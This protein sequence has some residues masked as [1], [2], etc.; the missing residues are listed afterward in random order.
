MTQ[1]AFLPPSGASAWKHCAQWS[2]M[3]QKFPSVDTEE[4]E[5][6]TAAHWACSELLEGRIH[7]ENESAPNGFALTGEMLDSA[8]IYFDTAE[9]RIKHRFQ[10]PHHMQIEQTLPIPQIGPDCFGTPDLW[11]YNVSNCRLEILDFKYGHGFVD[12]Y[13][14]P[15]GLL[16]ML[17]II[18]FLEV[19]KICINP[20]LIMVSF[21]I[22]QPRCYYRGEP[23]RTHSYRVT[24]ALPHVQ[25]L[26]LAAGNA[27]Q[28]NPVAATGAHCKHCPGRHA[29]D[30]LQQAAYSDM[31]FSSS[32]QPHDLSPG[33][34][35][36]E[37][38][39]LES[40]YDRIGARI[41]GLS[42]LV[43]AKLRAGERVPHHS[44]E[45]S[46]GRR[47]WN[48]PAEQVI[49]IGQ[50]LGKDLS[51]V[52]AITPNQAENKIDSSVINMYS[53]IIPGAQKLVKQN[54]EKAS[55]VFGKG[56]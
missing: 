56:D 29:C 10:A 45:A 37:L 12:E 47:E 15:Q 35:S 50:M 46:R 9:A 43:T 7:Q 25:A 4:S 32:R 41:E 13:F 22:V 6:G 30:A 36:L 48:I 52:K 54:N 26:Q 21:T 27:R 40:A 49:T 42:E 20:E 34:A 24:E 23:V 2:H 5:E 39:M 1:H 55:R 18:N 19:Q 8:D 53:Q 33:A 14:N 28:L 31:E 11:A 3:N 16:Y 51:K 17:G 38:R 44:L